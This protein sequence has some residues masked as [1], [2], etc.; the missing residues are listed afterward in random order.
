MSPTRI[1]RLAGFQYTGPHRY[2][3]TLG[4]FQRRET[5][6]D[7]QL[8]DS[9]LSQILRASDDEGFELVAYTFMPDHLHMVVHGAAE[10][11][12]LPRYVKRAKQ[13]SGYYGKRLLGRP[14]WQS[15]YYERVLRE[16][17][18]TRHVVAYLLDNPVRAGLVEHA[19]DY[20]FS[21]S[22]IC[23]LRELID[24]IQI[25]AI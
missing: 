23:S 8:I 13:L 7:P 21:G 20:P 16:V 3:L 19:V 9:L 24:F 14:I 17:E 1:R 22:G 4:T 12:V 11:A 25:G 18:D 2:S 5:F 10:S 6:V 15:G